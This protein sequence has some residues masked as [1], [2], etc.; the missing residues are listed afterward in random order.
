MGRRV[1]I[2]KVVI[3]WKGEPAA[4]VTNN[5]HVPIAIAIAPERYTRSASFCQRICKALYSPA[6]K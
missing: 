6:Y 2:E 4:G 5:T 3:T 1:T